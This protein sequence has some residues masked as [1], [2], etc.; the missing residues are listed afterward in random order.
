MSIILSIQSHVAY[1][2]VGNKIASF[3]LQRL[4]HNI[5]NINTVQFSNHT[6]YGDWEGQIFSTEHL[7]AV[8]EG[9]KRRIKCSEISALITGYLGNKNVGSLI[10]NILIDLKQANPDCIYCLDPVFG[11]VGRG[12]FVT[13]EL[14]NYYRDHFIGCGDI[15]TPNHFEM[16]Y[17]TNCENTTIDIIKHSA[18]KLFNQGIKIILVTSYQGIECGNDQIG[19]IFL[20]KSETFFVKTP[21][22]SFEQPPNGSGDLVA[23]LF[24]DKILK[25]LDYKVALGQLATQ[26]FSIFQATKNSAQRELQIIESQDVIVKQDCDF[27]VDIY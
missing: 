6:G 18:S 5:I 16:N 14:A 12:L 19:M 13:P 27:C 3:S 25:K 1:G 11:D 17:L 23:A 9:V 8:W 21:K 22:L 4:K 7:S 24:L 20:T 10:N 2:Y 26:V 15:I